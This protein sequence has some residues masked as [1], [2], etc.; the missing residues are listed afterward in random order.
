MANRVHLDWPDACSLL[1]AS[2][3]QRNAYDLIRQNRLI[4]LLYYQK[5]N[6]SQCEPQTKGFLD[7]DIPSESDRRVPLV[8]GSSDLRCLLALPC[9]I[10]SSP[11]IT[12]LIK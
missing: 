2:A 8:T 6:C 7:N 10:T 12:P 3:L 11:D 5:V 4:C 1:W 9:M